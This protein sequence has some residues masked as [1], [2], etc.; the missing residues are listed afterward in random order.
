[1]PIYICI[2]IYIHTCFFLYAYIYFFLHA[3]FYLF[4]FGMRARISP[5]ELLGMSIFECDW[6]HLTFQSQIAQLTHFVSDAHNYVLIEER[7]G[8]KLAWCLYCRGPLEENIYDHMVTPYHVSRLHEAVCPDSYPYDI[9]QPC[10]PKDWFVMRHRV[11][12]REPT[13]ALESQVLHR[14]VE[15]LHDRHVAMHPYA[16]F[17]FDDEDSDVEELN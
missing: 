13:P 3:Y 10:A 17:A 12:Q 14:Y 4:I 7:I 2:Y 16:N 1:M 6:C 5:H 8:Q 9:P 15:A 11:V